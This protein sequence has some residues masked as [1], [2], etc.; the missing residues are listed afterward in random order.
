MTKAALNE[1][2]IRKALSEFLEVRT[3]QTRLTTMGAGSDDLEGG[4]SYLHSTAKHGWH[5][6]SWPTQFGGRDADNRDNALIGRVLKEFIVLL[7][8]FFNYWDKK[9]EFIQ[10]PRS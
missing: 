8:N 9:N 3:P 4:K 5:V 2:Y 10:K 7:A 6:P 1:E